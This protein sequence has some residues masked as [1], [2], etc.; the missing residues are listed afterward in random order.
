MIDSDTLMIGI[1]FSSAALALALAIG[2]LN[3][4]R[5]TYLLYGASGIV[6][7]VVA[8]SIMGLRNGRYDVVTQT[9]PFT[10]LLL[11]LVLVYAASRTFRNPS[12]SLWPPA[13]IG[14]TTIV[15]MDLVF[16]AGYSGIGTMLLNA[17]CAVILILCGHEYW[18][19]RRELKVPMMVNAALYAV[20]GISFAICAMVLL[21]D[22]QW[23]LEAPPK[24]WAE[25]ANSILALVGLTGIGAISLTLH[26]ARAARH[27]LN[28]ANT[29]ALTG[30]HNRRALFQQFPEN[31]PVP[32]VSV[33]MF[34]LDHFK[35]I[36]D[37]LGHAEGDAVLQKFADVMQGHLRPDD[38]VAR[39]GGEEFCVIL[40][41]ID[42]TVALKVAD[43]IRVAFAACGISI[44]RN[45]ATATV[46]AGVAMGTADEPFSSVLSRADAALYTAKSA[47]RNQVHLAAL[48][49]VA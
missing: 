27:H 38:V 43:R 49:L 18:K 11:G 23:V 1:A 19:G 34:D 40:P 42:R 31:V 32:G 47:G 33:V 30:V 4:K 21:I 36:N 5:E 7:V 6:M 13:L 16:L 28:E 14:I 12:A 10:I 37:R 41:G 15:P 20:C 39:L 3:S 29:D 45:G 2:W 48:R 25:D 35:Q 22:Q 8:L 44:G 17:S 26:H 46:S 24:N 9:I